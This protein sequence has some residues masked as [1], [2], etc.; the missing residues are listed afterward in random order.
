MANTVQMMYHITGGPMVEIGTAELAAAINEDTD[1]DE[2]VVTVPT[3][4][5]VVLVASAWYVD[6]PGATDDLPSTGLCP[7]SPPI[8]YTVSDGQ[9][10]F[11]AGNLD[12]VT[13]GYR[14]EGLG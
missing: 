1:L 7:C 10:T 3:G 11:K 9:V 5:A 6:D 12:G 2:G 4:M 13:I 14:I 8:S